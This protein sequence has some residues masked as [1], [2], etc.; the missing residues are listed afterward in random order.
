M[1]NVIITQLKNQS[2][3]IFDWIIYHFY[4]GFDSF[5]IFDDFS[6]DDTVDKLINI[7]NK[8]NINI[9]IEKT[10]GVGMTY[11][12]E[13]SKNSEA[14][15]GDQSLSDR[16]RR[17]FR[18]G[19]DIVKKIN[20]DAIC[21]FTDVDEF[22]VSNT[23]LKVVDI[24]RNQMSD[25]NIDQLIVNTLDVFD[26]GYKTGDWY[27]ADSSTN[28]RWSI[29]DFNNKKTNRYKS[30]AISKSIEI[31]EHVHWLK[32]LEDKDDHELQKLIDSKYRTNDDL[33]RI[34]HFRRPNHN[35]DIEFEDD[36]TLI[37]KI[38][39]LKEKYNF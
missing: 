31:V 29:S 11:R 34:H 14:Y 6:E 2:D 23:D 8:F 3:R 17:S 28:R 24:I 27:T 26:N 19:N 39:I 33:L 1:K 16:I 38:K 35:F 32:R 25:R 30:V 12:G 37:N 13:K 15:H 10:D 36:L 5:V 4:Q 21:S 22:Y 9:I 20:P 18:T 7:K